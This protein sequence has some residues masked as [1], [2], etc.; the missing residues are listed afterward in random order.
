VDD[1]PLLPDDV[2]PEDPLA[3]FR[4]WMAMAEAAEPD[5][6]GACTLATADAQGRPSLRVVLLRGWDAAGFRFYTSRRSRKGREMADRPEVA[7][8]FHWKSIGRQVRLEGRAEPTDDA[9]SDRYWD[10]RP[11]SSQLSA[12]ASSQSQPVATRADLIARRERVRAKLGDGPYERPGD[13]GGYCV[14]PR[15]IEFWVSRAERLHDRFCYDRFG[16][17]WAASRL[18]L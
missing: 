16:D 10:G 8:C 7:L 17:G 11:A 15:R 4:E 12:I 2:I 1:A 13:W 9:D 6:A 3:I 14:V 18:Q 5:V